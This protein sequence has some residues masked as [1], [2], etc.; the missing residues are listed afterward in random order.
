MERP[1]TRAD[2]SRVAKNSARLPLTPR[3]GTLA[4]VANGADLEPLARRS[5]DSRLT[6]FAQRLQKW[7]LGDEDQTL[8]NES[9][10]SVERL[11]APSI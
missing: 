6:P 8:E 9:R 10:L 2:A 3:C 11:R 5:P 4:V 7:R 1:A